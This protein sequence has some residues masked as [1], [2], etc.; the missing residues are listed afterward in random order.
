MYIYTNSYI[1]CELYVMIIAII[2]FIWLGVVAIYIYC[3]YTTSAYLLS[4][5]KEENKKKQNTVNIYSLFDFT[6]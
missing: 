6:S 3:Q 1:L 5:K 4:T 2:I